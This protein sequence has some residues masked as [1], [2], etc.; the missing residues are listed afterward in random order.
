MSV[1]AP[2]KKYT[3]DD[4]L[5]M[6][7]DGMIRWLVNGELRERPGEFHDDPRMPAM[8]V[9]NRFHSRTMTRVARYLDVWCDGQPK[10]RGEVLCGEA[11]V[12]LIPN[13][14]AVVGVDVVFVPPEV[15][16]VQS[17]KTTVV[18]GVPRVVVEILSPN[19]SKSD[20][21]EMI[22]LYRDAGVPAFWVLD[23]DQKTVVV[24]RPGEEPVMYN[25]K[26]ELV[27]DPYLPGFRVPVAQLF[28]S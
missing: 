27:G 10:P 3:A 21:D 2:E 22:E 1:L 9:R 17:N 19:D 14:D 18:E 24:H 8:T 26:Q 16:T 15:A 28:S 12:R 23:P 11:G 25:A 6:P 20:V 4:L 7:N 13:S 5:N